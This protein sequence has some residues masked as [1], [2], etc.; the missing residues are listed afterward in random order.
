[1][2]SVCLCSMSIQKLVL[3]DI[4][5]LQKILL[6]AME[7]KKS[8]MLF[9]LFQWW[10]KSELPFVSPPKYRSPYLHPLKLC[11]CRYLSATCLC[12]LAWRSPNT[13]IIQPLGDSYHSHMKDLLFSNYICSFF[14]A[15]LLNLL[16]FLQWLITVP[17][18]VQL[19]VSLYPM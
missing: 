9:P 5:S 1:M 6:K 12:N 13:I 17:L 18:Q 7:K 2:A 11:G 15:C 19:Y 3:W 4:I 16:T 8:C 10:M 14:L